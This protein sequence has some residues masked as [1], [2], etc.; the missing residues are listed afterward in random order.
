MPCRRYVQRYEDGLARYPDEANWTQAD[1]IEMEG[2]A[3]HTRESVESELR[4]PA[5]GGDH[6]PMDP[7]SDDLPY[8]YDGNNMTADYIAEVIIDRALRVFRE[9]GP[10]CEAIPYSSPRDILVG[11]LASC[12]PCGGSSSSIS[13]LCTVSEFL[14][15]RWG[16]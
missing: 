5:G 8:D 9:E 6:E 2:L 3:D 4:F 15:N 14:Q 7:D 16:Y 1:R 13:F 11:G 10:Y 12:E